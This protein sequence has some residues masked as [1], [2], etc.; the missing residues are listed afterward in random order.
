[1]ADELFSIY[2]KLYLKNYSDEIDYSTYYLNL[3]NG[4]D[5]N[6]FFDDDIEKVLRYSKIIALLQSLPEV[7]GVNN[8]LLSLGTS[9]ITINEKDSFIF[10]K[11]NSTLN[12]AAAEIPELEQVGIV[13]ISF[14]EGEEEVEYHT[15]IVKIGDIVDGTFVPL[16]YFSSLNLSITDFST[17]SSDND[18]LNNSKEVAREIFNFI[19]YDNEDHPPISYYVATVGSEGSF[20]DI[21]T[22]GI[23]LIYTYDINQIVDGSSIGG[24]SL[25][26]EYY[27]DPILVSI[28]TVADNRYFLNV[29]T[30]MKQPD[31]SIDGWKTLLNSYTTVYAPGGEVNGS[32]HFEVYGP[33]VDAVV[34][35]DS[36]HDLTG[37]YY[38]IDGNQTGSLTTISNYSRTHDVISFDWTAFGTNLA[39]YCVTYKDLIEVDLSIS[40]LALGGTVQW[41]GTI[42]IASNDIENDYI[43][44]FWST[45]WNPNIESVVHKLSEP[46]ND[47]QNIDTSIVSSTD[48]SITLRVFF[49]HDAMPTH[50][51]YKVIPAYK[52]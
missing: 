14:S 20:R 49:I 44:W 16:D 24:E 18:E 37:N 8:V 31:E 15:N 13:N 46:D 30:P 29:H 25:L 38:S 12:F 47:N 5:F 52:K 42:E 4:L 33:S 51:Y 2:A 45:N 50:I 21:K 39:A 41:D 7:E 32:G 17:V 40:N 26:A 19:W 34:L 6:Q 1:M 9:N 28:P 23:Y 10:N 36:F 43:I 22:F 11:E 35:Y 27:P 48:T 3:L